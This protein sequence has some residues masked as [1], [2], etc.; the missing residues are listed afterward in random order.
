MAQVHN[1]ADLHDLVT[2][3]P[4]FRD[5]PA[6]VGSAAS[7]GGHAHSSDFSRRFSSHFFS[8]SDASTSSST[9]GFAAVARPFTRW[10][11][12]RA[13]SSSMTPREAGS[14]PRRPPP[15][16][17]SGFESTRP[18]TSGSM[19]FG[20][21]GQTDRATEL[22][23][24]PSIANPPTIVLDAQK[25]S[26]DVD[27]TFEARR[28]RHPVRQN[29]ATSMRVNR[30]FAM[31]SSPS[32]S[33]E[34]SFQKPTPAQDQNLSYIRCKSC[35]QTFLDTSQANASVAQPG[36]TS[37]LPHHL[38]DRGLLQGKHS[39]IT[40]K[41]FGK[42]YR[43]HRIILDRAPFFE[44]ALSPP[45]CEASQKEVE[46][47]PEETDPNITQRAFELALKRLYGC[48]LRAEEDEEAVCLFATGCWLEMQDLVNDS[49]AAILKRMG[50]SNLAPILQVVS[51]NYYGKPG[52]RIFESAKAML[53]R[54]GAD[55]Q[56]GV[57]DGVP[58]EL[59]RELVGSDG[60]FV[61]DEWNRWCL[62]KK[63]LDRRLKA[64]AH[65]AGLWASHSS[66]APKEIRGRAV[67][68]KPAIVEQI[69]S[70][71]SLEDAPTWRR[72]EALYGHIEIRPLLTLLDEDIHYVHMDFEQLQ[73]VRNAKDVLG[74]PVLSETTIQDALWSNLELRQKI[75]N[76]AQ[77]NYTLGLQCQDEPQWRAGSMASS[78][79]TGRLGNARV[80]AQLSGS[81]DSEITESST[82]AAKA[83]D[84]SHRY[85]IPQT[86]R[87]VVLGSDEKT[88][89]SQG[90]LQGLYDPQ[91][92][93]HLLAQPDEYDYEGDGS[94]DTEQSRRPDHASS[95]SRTLTPTYSTYPP[96]RFAVELP[97]ARFLKDGRK[98]FSQTIF[99]AGSYW[100]VYVKK[101]KK[102][103]K[104]PHV[105]VY[106]HRA[107]KQ[108]KTD[109]I[110]PSPHG[111]VDRRI[112]AL[113][114]RMQARYRPNGRNHHI[115]RMSDL[116]GAGDV[117]RSSW[118]Y[119]DANNQQT[120]TDHG[121]SPH[122]S[123]ATCSCSP[124]AFP[125]SPHNVTSFSPPSPSDTSSENEN[126]CLVHCG[127]QPE[128]HYVPALAPYMDKRPTIKTYFKIFSPSRGGRVL[129]LYE[130]VPCDFN[131]SQ[132][133]GWKSST[134]MADDEDDEQEHGDLISAVAET[135][136]VDDHEAKYGSSKEELCE[137]PESA[138]REPG[139]GRRSRDYRFIV[140]LGVV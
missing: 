11:P 95:P 24:R 60:F 75:L 96:F 133:W 129:N 97:N 81:P 101:V 29:T 23:A 83:L 40:V 54:N 33:R 100:N 25:D 90:T 43:L 7:F 108:S 1:T 91:A 13:S 105:G 114:Q 123:A 93:S 30:L 113:E 46:L 67:R 99:Y 5:L 131:Y 111:A 63:L 27:D 36:E 41:V 44:S 31:Q 71:I 130:S 106:L 121:R 127:E 125:H 110:S 128:R 22:D 4:T 79:D 119:P 10:A 78:E 84:G 3:D 87:N 102:G 42:D 45:W 6:S 88:D 98:V 73:S 39:D 38:L 55:L 65:E 118:A 20:M 62:A 51:A 18:S 52:E 116:Y 77:G 124:T 34:P 21:D 85:A 14:A 69:M 117:S 107:P 134:L 136:F 17:S 137:G 80:V 112:G 64:V 35:A 115:P 48:S 8:N 92:T 122:A 70:R 2:L 139:A 74:V 16:R 138:N 19:H 15:R 89:S 120:P 126:T 61:K 132:S 86:D 12:T 28:R 94:Y 53:C 37:S 50:P 59:V 76:A 32:T 47:H 56:A 104:N 140:V 49:M 103:A 9:V 57:W 66:Q 109:A 68:P 72:W 58:S 82:V 26:D 135:S